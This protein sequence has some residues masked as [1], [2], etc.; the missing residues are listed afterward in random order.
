MSELVR[1][2]FFRRE[3]VCHFVLVDQELHF[4]KVFF[5]FWFVVYQGKKVDVRR[6][7][8]S[9]DALLSVGSRYLI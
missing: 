9:L 1:S 7:E 8:R 4:A 5:F 6:G 3:A 2:E